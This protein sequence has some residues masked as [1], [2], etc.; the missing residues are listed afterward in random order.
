MHSS[1]KQHQCALRPALLSQV[2]AVRRQ[3]ALIS[4]LLTVLP[5]VLSDLLPV[6]A[7]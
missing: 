5:M 3:Q 1:L 2:T 7:A 6:S 4:S